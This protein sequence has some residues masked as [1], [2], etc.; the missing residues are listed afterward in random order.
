MDIRELKDLLKHS[1]SVVVLD[2]G[3]PAYVLLGYD[4]YRT[5]TTKADQNSRVQEAQPS[6]PVQPASESAG[7]SPQ[8]L[9]AIERLNKEILALKNQ[10]E[11]EERAELGQE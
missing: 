6:L 4:V 8:E 1:S 5:L 2:N 7:L 9:E 11:M 10:I 3:E